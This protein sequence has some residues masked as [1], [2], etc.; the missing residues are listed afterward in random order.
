MN[1]FGHKRN[2]TSMRVDD[3]AG[4]RKRSAN[5]RGF[6]LIELLVTIL[7]IAILTSFVLGGMYVSQEQ[8]RESRTR[9]LVQNL[10]ESIMLRWESYRTRRLPVN[11]TGWTPA[12]RLA[13]M[14]ELM[15]LELPQRFQD[16][17]DVDEGDASTQPPGGTV[18]PALV[19]YIIS[20]DTTR[21]ATSLSEA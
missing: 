17:S 16:F 11:T 8:A 2:R 12:F 14:R 5:R 1:A 4:A 20:T 10:N 15:R 7:I 3:S 19:S 13:G 18:P 21:N 6:T 9:A